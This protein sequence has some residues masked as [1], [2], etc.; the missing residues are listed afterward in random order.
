MAAA[1]AIWLLSGGSEAGICA[2]F[3]CCKS[4]DLPTGGPGAGML[5][6]FRMLEIDENSYVGVR[7]RGGGEEEEEGVIFSFLSSS[8]SSSS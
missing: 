2:P 1:A 3:V 4:R 7:R 6:A 8:D 5:C